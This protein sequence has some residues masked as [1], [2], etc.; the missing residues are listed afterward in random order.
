MST[1]PNENKKNEDLSYRSGQKQAEFW[2]SEIKIRKYKNVFA[3]TT[4][5][6]GTFLIFKSGGQHKKHAAATWMLGCTSAFS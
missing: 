4:T 2:F 1:R 3:S 6:G 5:E